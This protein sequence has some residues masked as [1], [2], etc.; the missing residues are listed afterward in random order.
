MVK[1]AFI[2]AAGLGSRLNNRTKNKPKALVEV[3]GKPMLQS[4][5]EKLK[6]AGI[7]SFII[8]V[9]HFG[10]QVIDFL[11]E[12]NYFDVQIFISDERDQLLDTGGALIKAGHLFKKDETILVHN[13]DVI[14][15][16]NLERFYKYHWQKQSFA[17]LSVRQRISGRSLL[18]NNEMKLI[19]WRNNT[20]NEYKWATN[21]IEDYAAFA[22]N[23]IYLLNTNI[24][25]SISCSGKFSIVDAW[26]ELAT[27][28]N[29]SGFFDQSDF[30][31]DLGT[32]KKI[33]EAENYLK[34][35]KIG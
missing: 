13:V 9:H 18:F 33:N 34:N 31:F 16:M 6:L 14:S 25:N 26:L 22:F 5:I 17:T 15:D 12:K 32:A 3:A 35:K 10:Q 20:T 1:T 23:G 27:K 11:E 2:L 19:G 21:P 30:W 28:N 7:S 4:V 8:N 24:I 29:I